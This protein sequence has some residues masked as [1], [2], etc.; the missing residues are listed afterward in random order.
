MPSA[1]SPGLLLFNS[2]EASDIV[3]IVGVDDNK[4]RIPAHSFVLSGASRVFERI[5]SESKKVD[6]QKHEVAVTCPPDVFH[7]M[8][9]YVSFMTP[10]T[11][12]IL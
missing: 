3:F 11:P 8:L 6:G 10:F 1:P 4:W 12:H 7:A 9:G 5:I 2:E